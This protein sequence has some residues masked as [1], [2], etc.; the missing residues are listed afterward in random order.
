MEFKKLAC[1]LAEFTFIPWLIR[2][3][4]QRPCVTILV[5]HR[6]DPRTADRHFSALRS[7]YAPIS[8]QTYLEARRSNTLK[9]LPPKS[10]I[11]TIDD[12]HHSIYGLKEVLAAH[13]I[14][15]TVFLCSGFIGANR[16]FWFS[17]PGLDPVKRQYLKTVS[18]E[19]RITALRAMGFDHAVE[20]G[21]RESLNLAEVRELEAIVD[22]QSHSVSHPIL[23]AC[24]DSKATEEIAL[25]RREL[26]E[27]LGRRV[28][29]LAYPNGSYSVREL[30]IT[31]ESGYDCGL[32]MDPGFNTVS[33]PIYALRRLALPDDCD[34]P[35]LMIRSCGLWALLRA[36]R[37]RQWKSSLRVAPAGGRIESA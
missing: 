31:S 11:I 9:H 23:P 34:I 16:R 12:G 27:Q 36:M 37:P 7:V 8:L 21:D 29:A 18:D 26:E 35:E 6:L 28:N 10:V 2:E 22:F 15:V 17:A 3:V 20:F 19:E 13:R 1:R 4:V 25:S 5:Y 33:T 32:T 14:P 30:R 24:S